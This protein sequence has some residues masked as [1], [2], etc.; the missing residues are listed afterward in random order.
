MSNLVPGS[1]IATE[2]D[3]V[4]DRDSDERGIFLHLQKKGTRL[5]AHP[6]ESEGLRGVSARR[7]G[8]DRPGNRFFVV[9]SAYILKGKVSGG[10]P[11]CSSGYKCS[12]HLHCMPQTKDRNSCFLLPSFLRMGC[13]K[14]TS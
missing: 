14:A 3:C 5:F 10:N 9:S 4:Q 11:G 8:W 6:A 7:R 1:P 12:I 2:K 13:G